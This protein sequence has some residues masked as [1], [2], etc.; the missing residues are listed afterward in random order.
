MNEAFNSTKPGEHRISQ[1]EFVFDSF[2]SPRISIWNHFSWRHPSWFHTERCIIYD[3]TDWAMQCAHYGILRSQVD[4][5]QDS[6]REDPNKNRN[7]QTPIDL[8][9]V[10]GSVVRSLFVDKMERDYR[11]A[12]A[13]EYGL[14]AGIS[15]KILTGHCV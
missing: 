5:G 11:E 14:M 1:S 10:D 3:L 6:C 13:T 9:F 15:L 8:C 12:N 7:G 2:K 4:I